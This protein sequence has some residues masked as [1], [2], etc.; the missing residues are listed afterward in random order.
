MMEI[1]FLGSKGWGEIENK[2]DIVLRTKKVVKE[3]GLRGRMYLITP[4]ALI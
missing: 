2:S 1:L 3:T 4:S